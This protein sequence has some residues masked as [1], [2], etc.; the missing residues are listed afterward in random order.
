MFKSRRKLIQASFAISLFDAG[1]S[2]NGI[3]SLAAE[4]LVRVII[5]APSISAT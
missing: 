5:G 2:L 4:W 3:H 1:I